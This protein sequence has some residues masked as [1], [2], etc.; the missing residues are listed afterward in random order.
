MVSREIRLN[1]KRNGFYMFR[2]RITALISILVLLAGTIAMFPSVGV[3]AQ[4]QKDVDFE[5]FKISNRKMTTQQ[6]AIHTLESI[7][8]LPAIQNAKGIFIK[9]KMTNP[10][11]VDTMLVLGSSFNVG[12]YEGGYEI[13]NG[14]ADNKIYVSNSGTVTRGLV[15]ANFEGYLFVAAD[16]AANSNLLTQYIK[17][18]S[19]FA[20]NWASNPDAWD[21]ASV[22]ILNAGYYTVSQSGGTEQYIDIKNEADKYADLSYKSIYCDYKTVKSE[23]L[24]FTGVSGSYMIKDYAL[25]ITS[26]MVGVDDPKG[27]FFK[28]DTKNAVKPI[29]FKVTIKGSSLMN[30]TEFGADTASNKKV[31]VAEDG[32]VTRGLMPAGFKGYVFVAYNTSAN[33]NLPLNNLEKIAI[34]PGL[35]ADWTGVDVTLNKTGFFTVETSQGDSQYKRLADAIENNKATTGDYQLFSD[36]VCPVNYGITYIKNRV[37]AAEIENIKGVFLKMTVTNAVNKRDFRIAMGEHINYVTPNADPDKCL[38]FSGGYNKNIWDDGT[39]EI[40]YVPVNFSGYIFVP[41]DE[42][43]GNLPVEKAYAL[44]FW[45]HDWSITDAWKDGEVHIEKSGYYSVSQMSGEKQYRDLVERIEYDAQNIP[46]ATY[47]YEVICDYETEKDRESFKITPG[48]GD[49]GGSFTGSQALS[50]KGSS[51]VFTNGAEQEETG[52]YSSLDHIVY[53]PLTD[54]PNSTGVEKPKIANPKGIFFRLK[55]DAKKGSDYML[56]LGE[57]AA[58][59]EIGNGSPRKVYVSMSGE[60]FT[61]STLPYDDFDGWVFVPYNAEDNENLNVEDLFSIGVWFNN[62][63]SGVSWKGCTTIFDNIGYYSVSRYAGSEQYAKMAAELN[64]KYVPNKANDMYFTF[65]SSPVPF[66]SFGG[67]QRLKPIININMRSSV[68]SNDVKWEVTKGYAS[69]ELMDVTNPKKQSALI[70]FTD[71]GKT[72]LRV[73]LKSNSAKYA[74]IEFNV[75]VDT[76]ELGFLIDEANN[77]ENKYYDSDWK[78]FRKVVDEA[79]TLINRADVT[80]EQ[81]KA[82]VSKLSAAIDKILASKLRPEYTGSDNSSNNSGGVNET[83]EA[84]LPSKIF[85]ELTVEIVGKII[86]NTSGDTIRIKLSKPMAITSEMLGMLKEAN[87]PVRFEITRN[88]GDVVLIWEFEKLINTD[89]DLDLEINRRAPNIETI[90]REINNDKKTQVISFKHSGVLPG[91]AKIIL[92]NQKGLLSK[93]KVKLFYFN[94]ENSKLENKDTPVAISNDGKYIAFSIDHCSDYLVSAFKAAGEQVV[95]EPES[96]SVWLIVI[97]AAGGVIILSGAAFAIIYI[98]KR[99]GK[100]I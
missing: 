100:K 4:A 81:I 37:P 11:A 33:I 80:K 1:A 12:P 62:W 13:G 54:D 23:D 36:F 60:A 99:K 74:E 76:S 61:A 28:L 77:I 38:E 43:N 59:Y 96:F 69:L 84:F 71:S 67:T 94:E 9:L 82:M 66:D 19:F 95:S 2:K 55:T 79:E 50:G 90:V 34:T 3:S 16:A 15:P 70:A 87:K 6:G 14:P 64:A 52:Y 5:I 97:I 46:D 30:S 72:V 32:T 7:A 89:M 83:E 27:V 92:E 21:G 20:I 51:I 40:G 45:A 73:S 88:N 47:S 56:S 68:P 26:D 49:I 42:A 17:R 75:A 18:I 63:G 53:R 41:F 22:E 31:F 86:E 8:P 91:T 24:S 65:E 48:N 25:D 35:N 10:A 44:A 29:D 98:L 93:D 57:F 39:V 85:R 58:Q 78:A